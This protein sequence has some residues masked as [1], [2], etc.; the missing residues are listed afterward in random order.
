MSL[1]CAPG[2]VTVAEDQEY[3]LCFR[4]GD[5]SAMP[6][7]EFVR[8]PDTFKGQLKYLNVL[9]GII[10]GA[11]EMIHLNVDCWLIEE[12]DDDSC[13]KI[14]IKFNRLIEESLPP[15]E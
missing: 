10:K 8:L 13:V 3:Q 11:F 6:L 5:E 12:K 14:G 15:G 1:N 4:D 9:P 2:L 7:L